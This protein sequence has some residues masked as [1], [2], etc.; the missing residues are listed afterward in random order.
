V[1]DVQK[2]DPRTRRLAVL[3]VAGGTLA[4]LAA[5]WF[6]D[7]W[8]P[9]LDAWLTREPAR[10]GERLRLVVWGLIGANALPV[11]GLAVYLW[12]LGARIARAERFPPPGMAVVRDTVVLLGTRAR[13]RGRL[14][15]GVAV[16]VVAAGFG[17]AAALWRL[18][19][20]LA[21][22]P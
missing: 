10:T 1:D 3:L 8:R 6:V 19:S 21:Y 11:L 4:G 13:R 17:L 12:R 20:V 9:A 22:R 16:L 5:I 14:V 2:A 7:A 15:Q 18:V